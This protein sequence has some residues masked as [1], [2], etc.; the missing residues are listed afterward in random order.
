M[1]RSLPV[2]CAMVLLASTSP[3]AQTPAGTTQA[4][5]PGRT[6]ADA[7]ARA[8]ANRREREQQRLTTG[9]PSS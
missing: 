6:E 9:A 3:A 5:R 1:R 4:A 8:E 7:R 2:L